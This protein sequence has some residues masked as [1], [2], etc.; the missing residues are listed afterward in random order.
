MTTLAPHRSKLKA[1]T[2][3]QSL[4]I[5]QPWPLLLHQND[6]HLVKS[7]VSA[8]EN[9]AKPPAQAKCGKNDA[10]SPYQRRLQELDRYCEIHGKTKLYLMDS[11]EMLW[12]T[13]KLRQ[14]GVTNGEESSLKEEEKQAAH[15][16]LTQEQIDKQFQVVLVDKSLGELRDKYLS[17]CYYG[18][19]GDVAA[20]GLPPPQQLRNCRLSRVSCSMC[21]SRLTRKS[22]DLRSSISTFM[23]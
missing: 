22:L 11:D 5:H 4:F 14:L 20:A 17:D 23:F 8:P 1:S 13:G 19:T 21:P 12:K 6:N 18:P 3:F 7:R 16:S 2:V 10:L 9:D 15:N